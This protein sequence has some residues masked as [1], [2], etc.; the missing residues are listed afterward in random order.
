AVLLLAP[1]KPLVS[2]HVRTINSTLDGA[3]AVAVTGAMA[4]GARKKLWD[5]ASI[6]VATPQTVQSDLEL[7][8]RN[9]FSLVVLDEVHRAV[10]DYAYTAVSHAFRPY[11]TLLGLTASPGSRKAKIE[12]IRLTLGVSN[13]E[14]REHADEDV[15][16]Y[17]KE[18]DIEWIMVDEKPEYVEAKRRIEDLIGWY[19]NMVRHYGFKVF[20][21]SRKAMILAQQAIAKSGHK[22]KY[23]AL[24]YLSAAINLDYAAE[25]LE[26]QSMGAFLSYVANLGTRETKGAQLLAKDGRLHE[27]IEYVKAHKVIHPKMERLVEMLSADRDAKYIVFSQYTAQIEYLEQALTMYGFKCSRFTGQRKGFTRKQQLEIIER[28]RNGEFNVLIA[29][30]IGEEGLDIPSVDYVIFYEPIPSEI[31]SIQRRGRAGRAKKGF[32]RILIARNTRDEIAYRS[33]QV[34]EGRMRRIIRKMSQRGAP[35]PIGIEGQQAP[36]THRKTGTLLDFM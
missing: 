33:S 36:L 8:D 32:V 5:S 21:R 26:S 22:S 17:V 14:S 2:Q 24:K 20:S 31:R 28:F 29:S 4:K 3:E 7:I 35:V 13:V 12:E 34:K 9:R 30:S 25:M 23:H 16:D 10:G 6:I 18:M 27:I 19:L 1:T 15:K 11:S